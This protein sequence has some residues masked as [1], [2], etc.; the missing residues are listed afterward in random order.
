MAN[1]HFRLLERFRQTFLGHLRIPTIM[2]AQS[3]RS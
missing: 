2:I 1:G 3:D